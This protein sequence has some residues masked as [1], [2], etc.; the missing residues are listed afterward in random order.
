MFEPI[1][2][3]HLESEELEEEYEV[4][5]IAQRGTIGVSILQKHF[6][7]EFNSIIGR[8]VALANTRIT[9]QLKRCRDIAEEILQTVAQNNGDGNN[10]S[11]V[12]RT[13]YYTLLC[14]LSRLLEFANGHDGIVR[15]QFMLKGVREFFEPNVGSGT[16]ADDTDAGVAGAVGGLGDAV[17]APLVS[18]QVASGVSNA[19]P[20]SFPRT[21]L[22]LDSAPFVSTQ[23]APGVSNAQK[24]SFSHTNVPSNIPLMPANG[25]RHSLSSLFAPSQSSGSTAA[26]RA[27][28]PI[29]QALSGTW[30]TQDVVTPRETVIGR[31]NGP[32]FADNS[33]IQPRTTLF[34]SFP[35]C[36]Q[37]RVSDLQ[38]IHDHRD[39]QLPRHYSDFVRQ[40]TDQRENYHE[41][42]NRRQ[43][44]RTGQIH[45]MS[46]WSLRFTGSNSPLHVDDFLFRAQ[47]LANS[48]DIDFDRLPA[49]MPFVLDGEAQEWFW[50][51][52]RNNPDSDWLTFKEAMRSQFSKIENQ[53][54]LW[55]KIRGRKQKKE[56]TFGQF[57]ITVATSA[58]R[59]QPPLDE[60][61]LVSVLRSNMCQGLKSA[62]LY[63][64]TQTLGQLRMAA[65]QYEDLQ[66]SMVNSH[67]MDIRETR[68]PPRHI[69]ELSYGGPGSHPTFDIPN[70][71]SLNYDTGMPAEAIEA[72]SR[73]RSPNP[74]ICWNCKEAGHTFIDCTAARSVFCY[75]CGA[76]N[77][78]RPSC[79]HCM[80]GNLRRGATSASTPRPSQNPTSKRSLNPFTRR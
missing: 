47:T 65:M 61:G 56:E 52:I 9:P 27:P 44:G 57:Y 77:T 1:N 22:S 60:Q 16:N 7:D 50:I 12:L 49:G 72:I 71:Q 3:Y 53:F 29:N 24:N 38:Q 35:N 75:G 17:S 4:R 79:A 31:G 28:P 18:A 55:D 19:Q 58:A 67:R 13:R 45:Q 46:K 80:S 25:N 30:I 76:E 51:Y 11:S 42:P 62:L 34:P 20:I 36:N 6:D 5:M 15:I 48:F 10:I 63:Q 43:L 23:V 8:P 73:P 41:G 68:G 64:N 59:L 14:R 69:S 21:T 32:N 54:D 26:N 74:I 70:S 78:Y 33:F 39:N 2:A 40:N 66:A 37:Q